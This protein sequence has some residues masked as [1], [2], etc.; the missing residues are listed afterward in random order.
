M[1]P[2]GSVLRARSAPAGAD[3]I[4]H[5]LPSGETAALLEALE[6]Y[7]RELLG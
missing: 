4:V 3:R 1:F 6:R 7:A 5:F 2:R